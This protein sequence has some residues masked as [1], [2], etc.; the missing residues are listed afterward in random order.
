MAFHDN[1]ENTARNAMEQINP[2]LV[3]AYVSVIKFLAVHPEMA[4]ALKGRNPP[5]IGSDDYISRQA[6]AFANSRMPKAP[7]P[8]ETVPDEMVS[9]ILNQYFDVNSDQLERIKRE[10]L[11][12]M[13][14]ENVVGDMLERYL[15]SVLEPAGWVWCSGAMVKAVDFV[16][17]STENDS[18]LMLQVKNRDNSENS[19]SSAIR[20]GTEIEKWHRTF[21][22]R[23]ETNWS[24]FPDVVMRSKL[25]EADFKTFVKNYIATLK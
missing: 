2:K 6:A 13:G 8:P 23:A 15:A 5:P 17:P 22:K 7:K 16:K 18:W 3:N 4:S 21:S 12:S 20:D 1:S 10:H 9:L 24:T 19:S 14:A 25:S 11:L